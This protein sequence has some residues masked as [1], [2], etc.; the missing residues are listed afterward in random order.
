MTTAATQ[1]VTLRRQ[2][3]G[4]SIQ[5]LAARADLKYIPVWKVLNGGGKFTA[6]QAAAIDAALEVAERETE[7]ARRALAVLREGFS[8]DVVG[9]DV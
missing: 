4:L 7:D 1:I 6:E 8:A 3:T 9:P 2:L 5:Q